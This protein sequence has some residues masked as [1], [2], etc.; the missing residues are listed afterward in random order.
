MIPELG[1]IALII[2][3]LLAIAQSIVPMAGAQTGVNSWIA[4]A[5]PVARA[6]FFFILLSYIALTYGFLTHDFSVKY[7]ASHSNT[8]LPTIYLI[9]GVWGA[10]EGSLLLWGLIL[11]FWTLMVTYFSRSVPEIMVAR[12]ISVMGMVSVGFLLFM[13]LT[14]NP[15]HQIAWI[16]YIGLR[17]P[18]A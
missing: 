14:S 16:V 13:L 12:V 7:V 6:Q 17:M 4:L 15:R 1:H 11:S 2:A 8:E 18:P 10:H 3:L 9:S 5:R